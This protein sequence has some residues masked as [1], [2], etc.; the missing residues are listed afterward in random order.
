MAV[1]RDGSLIRDAGIDSRPAPST[2]GKALEA[3]LTIIPRDSRVVNA[4]QEK[5]RNLSIT[6]LIGLS[7]PNILG[8]VLPAV[9]QFSEFD[10]DSHSPR[11]GQLRRSAFAWVLHGTRQG[12]S[13]WRFH[14][15]EF[16]DL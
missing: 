2:R 6:A 14:S 11:Q 16:F 9:Q 12:N 15:V 4:R 5:V 3:A 7:D 10:P 8:I 1:E 13:F